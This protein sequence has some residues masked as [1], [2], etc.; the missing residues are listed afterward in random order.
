MKINIQTTIKTDN[1]LIEVFNLFNKEMFY[2]LTE[3]APVKPVRY[4]GD[5]IG[6]E[7]HLQMN[8]PWKD[9]W[10]SVIT[11][12]RIADNVCFFVDEGRKLP[13]NI[14]QWRHTHIIRKVKNGVVIEDDIYFKSSN[15]FFDQFWW[16]A[17]N[18]QFLLRKSQYKKYLISKLK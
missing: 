13:Y 16:L 17:F 5:A 2:Y 8:F 4:D 1:K 7:I 6:S 18:P 15:W 9:E 14:K 10:I 3:N 11:E 12:R